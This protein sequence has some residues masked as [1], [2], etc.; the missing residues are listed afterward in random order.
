MRGPSVISSSSMPLL[1]Q[2][3]LSSQGKQMPTTSAPSSSFR[4]QMK[5]QTIQQRPNLPNS[6]TSQQMVAP[7]QQQQQQQPQQHKQHQQMPQQMQQSHQQPQQFHQHHASS[8]Q[9]QEHF[10]QQ[11]LQLRNQQQLQ[12]AAR[13]LRPASSKA[14]LPTLV[15]TNPVQ[16]GAINAAIDTDAAESGNQ[17]L[18]KR[19]I[20]ELVNQVF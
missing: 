17:I 9:P 2:Q 19:S 20:R 12:Q 5:Q 11:N 13:P 18:S 8:R 1:T 14:N 7:Q 6:M 10:S 4:P 15:Q 16:L 3:P